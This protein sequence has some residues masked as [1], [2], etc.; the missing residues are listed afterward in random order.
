MKISFR[1]GIVRHQTDTMGTPTFLNV[2]GGYVSIV[3]SPD[4]TIMAFIHGTKD[5]LY[6][7][8]Q[9]I[10]QAW[11][12]FAPG[13]DQWLYWQLN[14]STGI[15]EFGST[16]LE[17][18]E[19]PAMPTSPSIGQ[20]WFNTTQNLWYEWSGS[21]WVEVI[22]VFA[23]R[24]ENGT[25]PRSMS[26]NSPAFTGTQVGL[27]QS[28]RIGAL[29]FDNAGNPIRTGDRKFFTT[30]DAFVT[31][32]ASGA[33]LRVNNIVLP[34]IAQEPLA[35]YS[36]VE[37][38]DF[39]KLQHARPLNQGRKVFGFIEEDAHTGEVVNFVLEGMIVNED[40]D[41]VAAGA[42]VND[43]VYADDAGLISLTPEIPDQIPVGMVTG[44]HEILFTPRLFPQIDA[45]ITISQT[46]LELTD[47]PVDYTGL[48]GRF[49]RVNPS[50]NGLDF[51]IVDQDVEW[52]E[53]TGP[54]SA[55][56][57]LQAALDAKSNIGH[58]HVE[59]DIT[60]LDKYTQAA[61]DGYLAL[62]SDVSHGHSISDVVGL[63]TALNA[64]AEDGAN[65]GGGEG[66][67]R[68]K[69]T[70]T[71]NFKSLV[72]GTNITLTPGADTVTIDAAG[73]G[74]GLPASTQECNILIAD[75]AG[76]W[77]EAAPP[78]L[79]RPFS[80]SM[81]AH[82]GSALSDSFVPWHTE[83]ITDRC[84]LLDY[85]SQAHC[86]PNATGYDTEEYFEIFKNGSSIGGVKYTENSQTSAV[87]DFPLTEFDIGDRLTVNVA[88]GVNKNN[89]DDLMLSFRM[90]RLPRVPCA[91]P[92]SVSWDQ[93][94]YYGG[95]PFSLIIQGVYTHIEY[96][97]VGMSDDGGHTWY[98][99]D[100]GYSLGYTSGFGSYGY[101][102]EYYYGSTNGT[103]GDQREY[104]VSTETTGTILSVYGSGVS[105]LW[106]A[107]VFGPGGYATAT[108]QWDML[109]A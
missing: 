89:L 47:T 48:A 6:T 92:L 25:T 50:E 18:I 21:S 31:G 101:A 17:P 95:D 68:D 105:A 27:T 20:M 106:R 54:L 3:V 70:T 53:I 8:R 84:V 29:A 16:S 67:Y 36:V 60:D 55:Q 30:E 46:F 104:V 86:E 45:H 75:N 1:Q 22:R 99:A 64:K 10:A 93:S 37:Y 96:A 11:G 108:A 80:V 73:G 61:V 109:V 23:C 4:P 38:Y 28:K 98:P 7:E 41:W 74:S 51:G 88:P 42:D 58:T 78:E 56:V 94:S 9:S 33:Q 32:V 87:M 34:A 79:P 83:G 62:K 102:F 91:A 13:Q 63:Q 82:T 65:V 2:S 15:R 19:S 57:D 52:G 44:R 69:T 43:P 81:Y 24:L 66:L 90:I 14:P 49:V 40:W 107:T 71:L 77:A 76:G 85:G 39:N 26:I 97:C 100:R 103:T 72:A 12:P 35:E 59:A 5:Y